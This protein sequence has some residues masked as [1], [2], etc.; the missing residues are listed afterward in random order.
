MSKR[1]IAFPVALGMYAG[2]L[3]RGS[4]SLDGYLKEDHGDY[5]TDKNLDTSTFSYNADG[6]RVSG[7]STRRAARR[8]AERRLASDQEAERGL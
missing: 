4:P 6:V 8:A 3:A 1:N 7:F 5:T 2:F